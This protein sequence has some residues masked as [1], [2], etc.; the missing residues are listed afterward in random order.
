MSEITNLANH[1]L[2]DLWGCDPKYLDDLEYLKKHCLAAV[3]LGGATVI[4][5]SFHHFSPQGVS[6]VIIIAE[7]HLSLHTWP[8]HNYMAFDI[9][10]CGEFKFNL[11]C[12]YLVVIFKAA[13]YHVDI[14]K[15]GNIK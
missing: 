7:S 8:E 12:E 6:G 15:R 5:S 3:K 4:D 11:V 10:S 9:F 2:L 13:R 1:C 14:I